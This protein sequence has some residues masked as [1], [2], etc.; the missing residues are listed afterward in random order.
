MP[1]LLVGISIVCL[2]VCCSTSVTGLPGRD[3]ASNEDIQLRQRP[4]HLR[5]LQVGGFDWHF[6]FKLILIG[7]C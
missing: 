3:G 2:F 6:F 7:V 5:D 4:P 1:G